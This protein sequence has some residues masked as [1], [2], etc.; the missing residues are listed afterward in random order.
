MGTTLR[1]RQSRAGRQAFG[2]VRVLHG[3]GPCDTV[4]KGCRTVS[5]TVAKNATA[6]PQAR[7][8]GPSLA[9]LAHSPPPPLTSRQGGHGAYLGVHS[10]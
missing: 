3:Q 5:G 4:S 10:K 1:Q 8:P 6:A 2:W 7:A 9:W